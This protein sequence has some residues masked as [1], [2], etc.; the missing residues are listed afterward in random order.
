MSN[1]DILIIEINDNR[2]ARYWHCHN[3][4]FKCVNINE[5]YVMKKIIILFILVCHIWTQNF[6]LAA[7]DYTN[8]DIKVS[9]TILNSRLKKDFVGYEYTITNNLK[10]KLNIVNAQIINGQDGNTAYMKSE[11]EGGM[12]VTWAI[13]GPVGLFTLGLGWVVGII[14]TPIVWVVQNNKN[15]KTRTESIAYTSIVPIGTINSTESVTVRTLVP[16]GAKPQL[17]LTIMDS[18]KNLHTILK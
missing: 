5:E 9:Q 1:L 12:G 8:L 6:V 3:L 13:A 14:A 10:E 4:Y 17:K 18:A 7:L 2:N 11:V 15:K 16:I